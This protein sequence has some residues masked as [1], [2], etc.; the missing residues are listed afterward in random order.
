M[1]IKVF[2]APRLH[3]ALAKVREGFGPEAVILDRHKTDSNNGKSIWHVYAAKDA[4]SNIQTA[5]HSRHE[6]RDANF[7]QGCVNTANGENKDDARATLADKKSKHA[8]D[9]LT[10]I[11][12]A[13]SYASKIAGDFSRNKPMAGNLLT[14]AK[15]LEPAKR[16]E[17]VLLTGP[18]GGGKTTLAVKLAAHFSMQGIKVAFISTDTERIGGMSGLAAYADILHLPVTPLKDKSDIAAAMQK[19]E[20]ARLVLVDTEGWTRM[21]A[22]RLKRQ[23]KL[24]SLLPCSHR[25]LVLPANMDET[26]GIT[27]IN[28]VRPM[29]I[30]E[31][32]VS[33]LD[34]TSRPGKIINWA[35]ADVSLSYCSFGP[36]VPDQ[37]GWLSAKALTALLRSHDETEE[38]V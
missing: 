10:R 21:Q 17:L 20:S 35:A 14:W 26:D 6:P 23:A 31:L 25:L 18:S 9:F 1:Q 15:P 12:V 36:E 16:Q 19:T 29:G 28:Q 27:S 22:A 38:F 32:A 33:K 4:S 7:P 30:V 37:M 8:F 2:S 13:P 3:E 34:E 5:T 24:W 11:G